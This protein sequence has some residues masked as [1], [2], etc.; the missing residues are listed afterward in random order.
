MMWSS[1]HSHTRGWCVPNLTCTL[2][3]DV[4]LISPDCLYS[5]SLK[6]TR[7]SLW[8]PTSNQ[9]R[10]T[11]LA[12][13]DQWTNRY[14][15]LT[16]KT[17][18]LSKL[19]HSTLPYTP[20]ARLKEHTNLLPTAPSE[21]CDR[22]LARSGLPAYCVAILADIYAPDK[23]DDLILYDNYCCMIIIAACWWLTIS[24]INCNFCN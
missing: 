15:I 12:V 13:K 11:D 20:P 16:Q 17:E 18:L 4:V 2:E 24:F 19:Q 10:T 7:Y 22:V 6:S 21:W 5:L 3:G 9:A 14:T 1:S 23:N 8:L